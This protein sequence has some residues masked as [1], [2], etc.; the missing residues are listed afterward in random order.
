M[1]C[2]K[3]T[4]VLALALVLLLPGMAL[5]VGYDRIDAGPKNNS[6]PPK[7]CCDDG[8]RRA[9]QKF[10]RQYPKVVD[11]VALTVKDILGQFGLVDDRHKPR[12]P[13]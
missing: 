10:V 9:Y 3:K 2:V 7:D 4:A 1:S 8:A 11:E 13:R 5:A 6:S 12:P